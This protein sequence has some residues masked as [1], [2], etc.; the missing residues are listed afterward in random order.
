MFDGCKRTPYL[1]NDQCNPLNVYGAS[2]LKGEYLSLKYP[3]TLIL[4]TSWVY[5]PSGNNFLL[6]ILNYMKMRLKNQKFLKLLMIKEDVL[7]IQSNW[8]KFVGN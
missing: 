3:G 1:P 6:K 8:Q 5:G 4:R 7:L 2:K